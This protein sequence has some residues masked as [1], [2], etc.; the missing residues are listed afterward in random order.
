V[1][2]V[3]LA[4]AVGLVTLSGDRS[5][6]ASASFMTQTG[7]G[8]VMSGAAALAQ[9]FGISLGQDRPGET[10]QFYVDLLRTRAVLRRA[11]ETEYEYVERGGQVRRATLVEVYEARED[12]RL[13][14]P[15]SQAAEA[16]RRSMST[17]ITG[18]GLVQLT[19]RAPEPRLA[20]QITERLLQL[21]EE[22]N[23]GLRQ[24]RGEEEGD[25]VAARVS[26]AQAGLLTAE[27]RLQAFLTQ[28]RVF[29]HSPE[30][31]F[32]HGR[33]QRQVAIR[34]EVYT[35]LLRAY[36]QNRIDAL[37]DTPLLTVVDHP[38]ESARPLPRGTIMRSAMAFLLGL[39]VAVLIAFVAEFVRRTRSA[40][41]ARYRELEGAA[42]EA[43]RDLRRPMLW[44]GGRRQRVAT[45]NE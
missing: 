3:V 17:S 30:L 13:P 22:F 36:E 12:P 25:F 9:Q 31:V 10:S 7:D 15:W 23:T 33:L 45:R 11:V 38:A 18:T 21:L 29:D 19:V 2:P 14:V 37:R 26:D 43:W 40:G 41:D 20:E 42:R 44:V 39:T 32:E 34:Q 1:L 27:A 5:Y 28:N 35:S 24:R 4:L 8:R 16:L 6:A